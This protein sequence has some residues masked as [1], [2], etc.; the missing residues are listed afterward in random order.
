[1]DP[2]NTCA[3]SRSARGLDR[4][5]EQR[6]TLNPPHPSL[7][8]TRGYPTW[9][10]ARALATL[11]NFLN[12]DLAAATI[13]C[14]AI[15]VR[16]WENRAMPHRMCGGVQKQS[17]T[18]AD[19]L[20]LSICLY[21]YP[22]ASTDD[23]CIFIIANG[24]A[25]YNRQIVTRRCIDL[26]LTR[27]RS[28]REAYDTFSES[29]IRK[30]L[31]FRSEPPPLGIRRVDM[32]S[33]ID[34]DET[35]F[36]LK[37]VSKKYGRGHTTVRVRHPAH[38]TRKEVKLNVV[39][40]VEPGN[41]NLNPGLV[42]SMMHPRRWVHITQSNV[43]QL[44]F[45]DFVN[46]ILTEIEDHPVQG[47]YD[48]EK[49]ILWDNLSLHKTNYVTNIIRDRDSPN[50]FFAVDRPPYR[51]KLAPIEYVFCELAAELTRRCQRHW[52]IDIMRA[53]IY[54]IVSNIGLNGKLFST[55]VHCGYPVQN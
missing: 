53:N 23:I 48:D 11:Y 43:D 14:S 51:P 20:L 33:F 3:I 29:S 34:I 6:R 30:A 42:G 55:F 2:A 26:G 4:E 8:G 1:M 25:V 38:Y 52:T 24:G 49:C 5:V 19:Q 41:P 37:S 12:Y 10:R 31:W 22:D 46:D 28:S 9:Q 35:G 45:G 40:A 21:I 44:I 13:G 47:G 50:N 54:D 16:R 17:I 27:K 39:L 18:G 32:S 7:G 36:Y 15:S